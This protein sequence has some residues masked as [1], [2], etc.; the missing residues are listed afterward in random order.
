ME[1]HTIEILEFNK[2]KE[3]LK[4]YCLGK[5]G[6]KLID[7]QNFTDSHEIWE[8]K[9]KAVDSLLKLLKDGI[10]FPDLVFPEIILFVDS[11][12]VEGRVLEQEQLSDVMVYLGSA[13]RLRKMFFS[14]VDNETLHDTVS[15]EDMSTVENRLKKYLRPDGSLK[16]RFN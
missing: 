2:I 7:R 11:L 14:A 9:S 4:S 12:N 3:S 15:F 13:S 10:K 8:I 5:G 16:E 1:N 6:E